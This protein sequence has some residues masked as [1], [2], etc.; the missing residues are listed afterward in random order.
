[1]RGCEVID[2]VAFPEGVDIECQPGL[3]VVVGI[4]GRVSSHGYC[5]GDDLSLRYVEVT[6]FEGRRHRLFHVEPLLP[7][8]ELVGYGARLGVAQDVRIRCTERV[9]I[10]HVHYQLVAGSGEHLNARRA[11]CS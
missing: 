7:V 10:P 4:E 3:G 8:G 1:M 11:L 2:C 9:V 5:Y 6:D